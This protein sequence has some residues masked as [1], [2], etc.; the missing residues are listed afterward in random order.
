MDDIENCTVPSKYKDS[1]SIIFS[2]YFSFLEEHI[3]QEVVIT[4][5]I[6]ALNK[7]FGS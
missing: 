2:K 6:S 1:L 3:V 4:F 7:T 5:P